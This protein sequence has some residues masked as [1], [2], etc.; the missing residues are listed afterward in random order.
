VID[1]LE[2]VRSEK[3]HSAVVPDVVGV[4]EVRFEPPLEYPV[5]LT[6]FVVAKA[7]VLAPKD[8]LLVNNASLNVLPVVAV[9]LCVPTSI[10]CLNEVHIAVDIA[11]IVSLKYQ[12]FPV[13]LVFLTPLSELSCHS[14]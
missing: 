6:S 1:A 9:K 12:P 5:P 11:I 4:T 13:G 2:N 7:V 3:S 10:S 8:A 14:L